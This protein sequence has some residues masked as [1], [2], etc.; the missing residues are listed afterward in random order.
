MA[1]PS[2]RYRD[3]LA[4]FE[5][6]ATLK[7]TQH[8]LPE[9]IYMPD[10]AGMPIEGGDGAPTPATPEYDGAPEPSTCKTSISSSEEEYH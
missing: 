9:T 2:H 3:D 7:K 8:I 4:L 1:R 5:R 6:L 10:D